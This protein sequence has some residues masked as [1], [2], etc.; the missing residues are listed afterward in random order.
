ML[1]APRDRTRVPPVVARYAIAE[2]AA[3][4]ARLYLPEP[5]DRGIAPIRERAQDAAT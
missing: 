1:R 4:L 5:S 3:E 2:Q